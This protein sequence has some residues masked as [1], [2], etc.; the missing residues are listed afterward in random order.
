M[1]NGSNET[2]KQG[3][4]KKVEDALTSDEREE[5]LRIAAY[6]RWKA[7]G[8]KY[9]TDKDDWYEAEDLFCNDNED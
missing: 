9:G 6:Y 7:K 8:K 2:G 4:E 3:K 5:Q 1:S